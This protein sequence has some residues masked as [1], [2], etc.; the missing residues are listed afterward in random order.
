MI[1][2]VLFEDNKSFRQSLSMYLEH[3]DEIFLAGSYGE[4]SDVV[5]R[6]QKHR[7]DVV[8]M[9]IQMPG[10]S[11]L[12]A[13]QQIKATNPAT[14]VL[15]QTIFDDDYRIFTAICSGASGYVLKSPNPE[16]MERAIIEVH[17][18]GACMS[19]S[20]AARVMQ[21]FKNQFV[22]AQP[23]YVSL[24]DRER[25]IL[26]CMV[27]GM[28]YKMIADAC[29]LSFHTVHWHVKNIYDKLH[30]NSA[31]EAVAKAIEGKLV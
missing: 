7:P 25:E 28:S 26:G 8:L 14:K 30:V 15:M 4:A 1:R 12:E 21:M 31:P 17:H 22:Q 20:I 13:L 2:V 23:T 29:S 6:V 16:D 18:G 5:R 11:G 10:V 27:K 24:T 3:S 19:P 9:D